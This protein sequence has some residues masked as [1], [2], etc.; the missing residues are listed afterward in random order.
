MMSGAEALGAQVCSFRVTPSYV[1]LVCGVKLVLESGEG[2]L[3]RLC[4][5]DCS[6]DSI[7]CHKMDLFFSWCSLELS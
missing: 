7:A 5:G 3:P 6:Y 2:L 1:R 4:L